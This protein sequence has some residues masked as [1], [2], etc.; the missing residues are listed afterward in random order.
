M[1]SKTFKWIRRLVK[2]RREQK[3][4]LRTCPQRGRTPLSAKVGGKGDVCFKAVKR[5]LFSLH[6][7]SQ[8][9]NFF[10]PFQIY[11]NMASNLKMNFTFLHKILTGKRIFF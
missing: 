10:I 5:L 2:G 1:S 11:D 6:P 4:Y 8:T 7:H 9:V 3:Q